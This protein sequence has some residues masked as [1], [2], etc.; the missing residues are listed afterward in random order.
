MRQ[1]SSW[2]RWIAGG[3]GVKQL[4]LSIFYPLFRH[5]ISRFPPERRV[6]RRHQASISQ[7]TVRLSVAVI[8]EDVSP[9]VAGKE[10]SRR[11]F[12]QGNCRHGI[13]LAVFYRS[14]GN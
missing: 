8:D 6:E 2:L 3:N 13:L 9:R 1:R 5:P 11:G 4:R 10:Q 14:E 12:G 7:F